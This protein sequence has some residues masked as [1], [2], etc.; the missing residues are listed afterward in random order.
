[1]SNPAPRLKQPYTGPAFF[2][3][4]Y[5]PM[6]LL[7]AA[8]AAFAMIIWLTFLISGN[9]LNS[10]LA[11]TNWHA[12]EL[13]FGFGAA[14]LCGF[15]FT[16]I[17]NW[18]GRLPIAGMPLAALTALWLAARLT[19]T[20]G[21]GLPLIVVAVIDLGFMG[22]ICAI[23]AR[24]IIAGK[25][26]RNLPVLLICTLFFSGNL[27][28]H[29]DPDGPGFRLGLSALIML[30]SLIGGRVIPSFTRNWLAKQGPGKL[31]TPFNKFDKI[32]LAL[33]AVAL[34]AWIAAPEAKI[35][36]VALL[37]SGAF[38]VAR[39]SRWAVERTL[40]QPLVTI[41]HV[42]YA[43]V[44]LGFLINGAAAMWPDTIPAV[45]G[46][47]TWTT[48]AVAVM[49]LAIMTR[50]SLGHSG[51]PLVATWRE[52]IIYAAAITA[53]LSRIWASLT[54]APIAA[55]HLSATA[56]IIAFAAFCIFYG[57]LLLAPKT[58][59]RKPNP[60]P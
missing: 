3:A 37:I 17:P 11:P 25:N 33:S 7:G 41:L 43:F 30:I 26:W 15:L 32:T 9:G 40:N 50:A 8:W 42:G 47:H 60:R 51:R 1:M 55:L 57:P 54:D 53:A 22:S 56:W 19:L 49:M 27:W 36:G 16:A 18:T 20:F 46:I 58:A 52:L 48:G 35:T 21:E 34:I 59:P 10:P 6:F 23:I 24:E 31:P 29:I 13:L 5:R 4:G 2:S 28:F 39:L 12:H 44:P 45:A 14:T 38:H